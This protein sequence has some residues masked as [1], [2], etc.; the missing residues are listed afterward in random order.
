[1]PEQRVKV[2]L[3]ALPYIRN[4]FGK[5]VVIKFGGAAMKDHE[6]S[7]DF[8]KDVV[9]LQ[10]VGIRPVIVHGGGPQINQLLDDLKIQSH[11]VDGHRVTD[12]A[13][14]EV[15]EMV[16]AGRVNKEIVN[17]INHE[18]GKAVGLTGKDGILA[19]G[20]LYKIKKEKPDGSYEE[21]SLGRVGQIDSDGIN[22]TILNALY[23]K[24]Y[25]PVIAPVA[26]D[27]EGKSLNINADT[28]AGA[29]AASLNAEKLILLTDTPG[30]KIQDQTVTGLNPEEV[31]KY[32][33][34]K[35][36]SGGM[37]PKVNCCL[38]ALSEGT[39]SAHIIDGRVP[40]ALLLEIFTD[41]GVGT[42]ITTG[43]K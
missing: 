28:M 14:M 6:L 20:S 1:M 31:K 21:I 29:V 42:L 38:N 10:Y 41:A 37:L 13:A 27:N 33:A 32:I 22:P 30:V 26:T 25:I 8:A 12:D 24:G 11:F 19:K 15:V 36:I 3:E 39:H 2:L 43:E 9:L 35:E 17:L 40:H 7:Q 4:F 5:T 18:G 23:E 16:L 34:S